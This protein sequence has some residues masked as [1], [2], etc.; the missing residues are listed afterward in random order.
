MTIR[1]TL[2]TGPMPTVSVYSGPYQACYYNP[3]P[4]HIV[5]K[6]RGKSYKDGWPYTH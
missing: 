3:I 2:G 6:M 5:E 4:E 1:V